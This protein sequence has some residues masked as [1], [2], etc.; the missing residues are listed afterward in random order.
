MRIY[1]IV[2]CVLFSSVLHAQTTTSTTKVAK[3]A[4]L[5]SF[6]ADL[7][8]GELVFTRTFTNSG[9]G[10]LS[11]TITQKSYN[12]GKTVAV[13]LSRPSFDTYFKTTAKLSDAYPQMIKYAQDKNISFTDEK[14]WAA[15][16]TYYNDSLVK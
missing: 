15:L 2:T 14:G 1:F 12:N 9:S 8:E 4:V 6:A 16:I 3:D 10:I 13:Q 5:I 7:A 11:Y